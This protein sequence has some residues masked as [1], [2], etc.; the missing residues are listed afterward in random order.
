MSDHAIVWEAKRILSAD[1]RFAGITRMCAC[2]DRIP[3][4]PV[5][6]FSH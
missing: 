5:T 4:N 1:V 3:E 2:R 6:V